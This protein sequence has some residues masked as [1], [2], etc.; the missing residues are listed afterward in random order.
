MLEV[1]GSSPVF[2]TFFINQIFSAA[3]SQIIFNINLRICG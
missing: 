2:S 3:D 1:T